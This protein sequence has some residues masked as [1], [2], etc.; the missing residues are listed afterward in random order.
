M[1]KKEISS[2]FRNMLTLALGVGSAKIIS[3]LAMPLITRMYGP[4]VVGV[5]SIFMS[6]VAILAP[7]LSLRYALPLPLAKN[8]KIALNLFFL[9]ILLIVS[10]SA[11]LFLLVLLFRSSTNLLSDLGGVEQYWWAIILCAALTA[12]YEST[13]YWWIKEKGFKLLSLVQILQS[14]LGVA[15]K[16]GLGYLGVHSAGLILGQ[17]FELFFGVFLLFLLFFLN[18]NKE[19]YKI[20]CRGVGL[21]GFRYKE[22]P[23]FRFPSQFLLVYASQAPL[24]F[25]GILFGAESAGHLGLALMMLALP[26]QLLGNTTGKAFYAE[27]SAL[28]KNQP[29]AIKK[30]SVQVLRRLFFISIIPLLFIL[31][32]GEEVFRLFF[33]EEWIVSGRYAGILSLYL[34]FQF[35]TTPLVNVMSVFEAQRK[36]LFLNVVRAIIVSMIFIASWMLGLS[37]HVTLYLYSALLSL[38]YALSLKTIFGVI[39]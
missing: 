11:L 13:S 18:N 32:L 25:M 35:V 28:G 23:I 17:L 38:H 16:L 29:N 37:D 14:G 30:I 33:G 8:N 24:I 22:Y 36:F 7:L 12:F 19:F 2:I 20:S 34:V 31:L 3:A 5:F 1:R 21:V 26:M 6:T 15:M 27:I 9:N 4:G 10:I 39:K